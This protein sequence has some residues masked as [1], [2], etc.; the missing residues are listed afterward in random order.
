MQPKIYEEFFIGLA[1]GQKGHLIR[2]THH[3]TDILTI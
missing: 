2:L 1:P 3:Q